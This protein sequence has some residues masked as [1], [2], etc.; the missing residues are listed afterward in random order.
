MSNHL[1]HQQVLQGGRYYTE[2]ALLLPAYNYVRREIFT[3]YVRG[4]GI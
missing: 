4:Q 3:L 2:R 1:S